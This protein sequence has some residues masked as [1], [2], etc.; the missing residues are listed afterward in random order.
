MFPTLL[1]CKERTVFSLKRL[2]INF[3]T[4]HDFNGTNLNVMT[5]INTT[6]ATK[7]QANINYWH[8]RPGINKTKMFFPFFF[9]NTNTIN[10]C[11]KK[12]HYLANNKE[13]TTEKPFENTHCEWQAGRQAH[14]IQCHLTQIYMRIRES[15]LNVRSSCEFV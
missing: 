15:E 9:M 6:V 3:V 7:L 5:L 14:F 11:F 13:K 12:I 10:S 8:T 1:H 2:S 4:R